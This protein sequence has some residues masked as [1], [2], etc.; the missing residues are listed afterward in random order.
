MHLSFY[1]QRTGPF[2]CRLSITVER[3]SA[4]VRPTEC[5]K[6]SGR[7]SLLPKPPSHTHITHTQSFTLTKPPRQGHAVAAVIGAG[8][9]GGAAA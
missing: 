8:L 3:T 4:P 6:T 1:P 2:L 5:I 7:R 9:T